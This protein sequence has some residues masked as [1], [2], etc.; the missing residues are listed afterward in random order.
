MLQIF[1]QQM[2]LVHIRVVRIFLT[3]IVHVFILLYIFSFFLIQQPENQQYASD[4][5]DAER[6]R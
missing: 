5:A 3:L 4:C 2:L 1:Q 6:R